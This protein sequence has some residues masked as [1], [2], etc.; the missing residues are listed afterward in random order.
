MI[1]RLLGTIWA[2]AFLSMTAAEP[3]GA[4]QPFDRFI[5]QPAET[6]ASPEAAVDAFKAKLTAGDVEG[7]ANL[8]GLKAPELDKVEDFKTRFDELSSAAKERVATEELGPDRKLVVLG[9]L[10][11]PF[12]FPLV[13]DGDTWAFDTEA[14]LEEIVARRIGENEIRAIETAQAYVAAQKAYADADRDDDSVL[15]YAQRLISSEGKQDGLYW[16][17]DE[18]G[19]ESP[20]GPHVVE[21]K[22]RGD[23][24]SDQGYFGYRFRI[25]RGQ[26]NEVAGGRYDYVINGNMIAGY[27]LIAWPVQYGLTGVKTFMVSHHGSIYEKDLG[28]DTSQQVAKIVRFN[29]DASWTLIED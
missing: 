26:G 19:E 1:S 4:A 14:G 9:R 7:T 8:L 18:W 17:E 16:P 13:R 10:V 21:A 11:W 5:G 15:E 24:G 3:G 27:A 2:F 22:L 29:P 6:F 20:A 12:P 28:G 23:K 25:L